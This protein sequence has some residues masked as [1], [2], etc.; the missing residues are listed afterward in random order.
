MALSSTRQSAP[1]FDIL[2]PELKQEIFSYLKKDKASL[3]AVIQ[4]SKA[5]HN[6]CI[7]MLWRKA[8]QRM[9]ARIPTPQ[10]RQHYANMIFRWTVDDY[11]SCELFDGI[12]FP[13]L[14][15][16][17]LHG[18]PPP[19]TQL[20]HYLHAG[21][22][23]LRFI[24]CE[25]DAAILDLTATCCTQLQRLQI[26]RLK[27]ANPPT[28]ERFMTFLQSFP[29]LR[30][31]ELDY[32]PSNIMNRVFEWDSGVVAKLEE[33]SCVENWNSEFDKAVHTRFLKRCTGLRKLYL[34]PV[35]TLSADILIQVLSYPLLELL[36]IDGCLAE[37]V[38]LQQQFVSGPPVAHPFPSIKDLTIR[39][40]T[41]TI[42]FL[43]SSSPKTLV[44]L[45]LNIV[46][47]SDSVFQTIGRL[48]N[49]VHLNLL[50]DSY[51]KLA[52][53]DLDHIAGL[54]RLQTFHLETR[55]D[56]YIGSPWFTDKYFKAWITKLPQ[57][58]VLFLGLE[59]TTV[60]QSSL[61]FLADS[62]PSLLRCSLLWEHD[63]NTWSS[64]KAPLFPKL[65]LLLLGKVKDHSH[66]E[67]QATIDQNALRDVKVIRNLAPNLEDFL[68]GRYGPDRQNP[69]ERALVAAF[70]AGI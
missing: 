69:Y 27:S 37:G 11:S 35:D 59:S 62:C 5:C 13:L 70:E 30:R 28:P 41:S 44:S 67:S 21:L 29:A 23:T 54:P 20:R 61:Q 10:R 56:P 33:L 16:M 45:D 17:L 46:D 42:N 31:L 39:S 32:I 58:R 22:H 64:L 19:V 3:F 43:L 25:L 12:D 2:P 6:C 8:T 18:G 4:V 47:N 1:S 63:L 40:E 15:N 50:C 55:S 26:R 65:E 9:L 51:N 57:L 14:K 66:Q 53:I 7:G 38:Q 49:L 52:R 60:T 48:P 36:D 68:I 24:C 34:W